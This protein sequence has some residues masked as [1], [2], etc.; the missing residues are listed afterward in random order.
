MN[1]GLLQ[2]FGR[3][4]ARR[5]TV[6]WSA[7]LAGLAGDSRC[8]VFNISEGGACLRIDDPMR[9]P[10]STRVHIAGVGEFPAR[11]AWTRANRL[12]VT[13]LV[14]PEDMRPILSEALASPRAAP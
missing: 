5:H 1:Q 7:A 8:L 13:F 9:V 4:R 10:E 3:R 11:R 2:D 14:A 6:I 12:G